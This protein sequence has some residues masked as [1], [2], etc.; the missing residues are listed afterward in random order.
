MSQLWRGWRSKYHAGRWTLVGKNEG[1]EVATDE[2][3][4]QRMEEKEESFLEY[5]PAL[6]NDSFQGRSRFNIIVLRS[7]LLLQ[8]NY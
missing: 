2:S 6:H 3:A 8:G 5:I 7:L 1:V 4:V